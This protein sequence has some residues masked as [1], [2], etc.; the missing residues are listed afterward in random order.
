MRC[1]LL[2]VWR[3]ADLYLLRLRLL[4]LRHVQ[5]QDPIV[6]LSPNVLGADCVRQGEALHERTIGAFNSEVILLVDDLLKLPL[7][8]DSQ[9]IV[10]NADVNVLVLEIGQVGL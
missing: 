2:A 7:A 8:A 10:C 3:D 6:I 5:G 4:T 9:G 1:G